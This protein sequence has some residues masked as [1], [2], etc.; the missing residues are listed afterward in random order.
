[1]EQSWRLFPSRVICFTNPARIARSPVLVNYY[2]ILESLLPWT[3]IR[4]G[5]PVANAEVTGAFVVASI[6]V[7]A[8]VMNRW[9]TPEIPAS[10]LD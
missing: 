2:L 1:M 8:R 3:G 10:A 7:P 4:E 5:G 9:R 6:P